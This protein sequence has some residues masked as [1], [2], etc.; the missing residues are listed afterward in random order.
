MQQDYKKHADEMGVMQF[1]RNKKPV[2]THADLS[3][4]ITPEK[5]GNFFFFNGIY[6]CR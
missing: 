2:T 4:K 1:S 6:D 3:R 5:Y